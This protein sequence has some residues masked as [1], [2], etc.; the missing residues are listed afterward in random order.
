[1]ALFSKIN[2]ISD[3]IEYKIKVDLISDREEEQ[4]ESNRGGEDI[5]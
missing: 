2:V 3:L 5:F 4:A 1:L